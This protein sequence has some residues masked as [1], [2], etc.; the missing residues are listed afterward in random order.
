MG[1]CRRRHLIVPEDDLVIGHLGWPR[2]PSRCLE[3]LFPQLAAVTPAN[4]LGQ[5]S[6]RRSDPREGSAPGVQERPL[7][8]GSRSEARADYLGGALSGV[9]KWTGALGLPRAP[10][11]ASTS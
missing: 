10:S 6:E 11:A 8:S 2:G 7:R 4:R 9:A 3:E 5:A 1:L